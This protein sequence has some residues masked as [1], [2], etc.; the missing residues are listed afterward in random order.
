MAWRPLSRCVHRGNLGGLLPKGLFNR[1]NSSFNLGN[2]LLIMEDPWTVKHRE[3]G[4]VITPSQNP[5][6]PGNYDVYS[7]GPIPVSDEP[8]FARLISHAVS[9]WEVHS[10]M[11]S[12]PETASV[13]SGETN[14]LASWNRG[15]EGFQAAHVFPLHL[16]NHYIQFN[17][18]RWVTKM[19]CWCCRIC[20]AA[21]ISACLLYPD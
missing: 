3:S 20:T 13:I 11:E 4:R 2:K 1:V 12:E 16:E 18:G 15:W 14:I 21:S 8:W 17:Y 6:V 10:E 9:G 7:D 19:D 5:V